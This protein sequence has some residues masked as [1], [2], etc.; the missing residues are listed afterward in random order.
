MPFMKISTLMPNLKKDYVFL[1]LKNTSVNNNINNNNNINDNNNTKNMESENIINMNKSK[2]YKS[3]KNYKISSDKYSNPYTKLIC[4]YRYSYKNFPESREQFAL[5]LN[6]NTLY[7]VGG[8][9]CLFTQEELWTCDLNNNFSW[10]KIKSTNGSFVRFGHTAVFDKNCSKIYIYGGR[11]KY[12]QFPEAKLGEKTYG[13]CGI[14]YYDFKTKEFGK[15]VM[16][17]RIQPDQRRNHIAELVGSDLVIMGGINENNDI[18]NDV[19][20]LNLNFPNG[21]KE[22]WKEIDIVNPTSVKKPFLFVHASALAVQGELQNAKNFHY[23]NIL[24][25]KEFIN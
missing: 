8:K 19:Y 25:M 11:T 13:F 14:E 3:P 23:I 15:P 6:D 24:M 16:S 18:L 9:S 2:K 20:S 21:I 1:S 22:R 17:Y 7:L 10:S 12:D 5:L 4:L